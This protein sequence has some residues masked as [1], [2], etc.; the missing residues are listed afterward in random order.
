VTSRSDR[1]GK[2]A[3]FE[4]PPIE[5][6]DTLRDD[7]LVE[8]HDIEG[9]E[10]LYSAGHREPGTAVITCSF[11]KVRSRITLIETV[12]RIM[13]ISLWFPMRPYSRWMQCPSC[14]QRRWCRV[15]WLA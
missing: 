5:I 6:D 11:C 4:T 10:A 15:E 2:R 8:R 12:V 9:H 7:P 3:L 1:E 14:Q 13:S